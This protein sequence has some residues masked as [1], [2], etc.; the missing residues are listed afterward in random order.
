MFKVFLREK[1]KKQKKSLRSLY[2]AVQ[3]LTFY[4]FQVHAIGTSESLN[5][6]IIALVRIVPHLSYYM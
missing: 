1:I 6:L 2:V 3:D 4:T 5:T